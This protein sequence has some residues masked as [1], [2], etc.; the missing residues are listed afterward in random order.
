MNSVDTI[1]FVASA[2][3]ARS[4]LSLDML[5]ALSD[6]LL[7]IEIIPLE[8]ETTDTYLELAHRFSM[9]VPGSKRRRSLYCL[10]ALLIL[11]K[12]CIAY[13]SNYLTLPKNL[14]KQ[15]HSLYQR[16]LNGGYNI[17]AMRRKGDLV[18]INM[19]YQRIILMSLSKPYNQNPDQFQLLLKK[20]RQNPHID[21]FTNRRSGSR[22]YH[23]IDLDSD[24]APGPAYL[25]TH[26]NL[27]RIDLFE[28]LILLPLAYQNYERDFQRF[29][30]DEEEK[31]TVL[32]G[33][34]AIFEGLKHNFRHEF[35]EQDEGQ[36][37]T[38]QDQSIEGLKLLF[39]NT[40]S[41][42]YMLGEVCAIHIR[43]QFFG[44][45]QIC[46]KQKSSL[47]I[48][49]GLKCLGKH[50]EAVLSRKGISSGP[51]HRQHKTLLINHKCLLAPKGCFEPQQS[52][53]IQGRGAKLDA[54]AISNEPYNLFSLTNI[55]LS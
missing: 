34:P 8:E 32:F 22:F 10:P 43:D 52:L 36:V 37:C 46:W 39:L 44:L 51:L 26:K 20:L 28:A 25:F 16:A 54:P 15:I 48:E 11:E 45:Y 7:S 4:N 6:K 13:F 33:L 30:F 41:D 21:I 14:W 42:Q 29:K 17:L 50:V 1:R 9:V 24:L 18:N 38:I 19:I 27:L 5:N 35:L 53:S 55:R 3:E 12:L 49:L 31:A 2:L 23:Y 40:N 47:G